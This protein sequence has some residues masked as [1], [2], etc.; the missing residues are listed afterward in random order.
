MYDMR[1]VN[2][3]NY[4]TRQMFL[5]HFSP[6][7]GRAPRHED[8]RDQQGFGFAMGKN[9]RGPKKAVPEEGRRGQRA[10]SYFFFI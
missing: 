9:G 8:H 1:F 2:V 10:V 3:N 6:G 4:V 5:I 7:E